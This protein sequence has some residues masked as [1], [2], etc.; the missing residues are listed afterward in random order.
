VISTKCAPKEL[1]ENFDLAWPSMLNVAGDLPSPEIL[2]KL[3]RLS[4]SA[5]G[6]PRGATASPLNAWRDGAPP[7]VRTVGRQAVPR[8]S[9]SFSANFRMVLR[10]RVKNS[11]FP[12]F[13]VYRRRASSWSSACRSTL[14]ASSSSVMQLLIRS[15][16]R[17]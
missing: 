17:Q 5:N 8:T 4:T 10:I 16:R 15:R 11:R 1:S 12:G 13:L 7:S 6:A 2:R 3:A 14:A 9:Q